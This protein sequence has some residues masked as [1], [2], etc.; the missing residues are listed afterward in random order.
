VKAT[1]LVL[2]AACATA[3]A[4]DEQCYFIGSVTWDGE[5]AD[6]AV[7][8]ISDH[9]GFVD[10][11]HLASPDSYS[12]GYYSVS[13]VVSQEPWRL[14]CWLVLDGETVPLP[15]FAAG[16]TWPDSFDYNQSWFCRIPFEW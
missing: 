15:Q 16:L 8:M 5:D 6:Y 1:I 12:F 7:V 9:A 2:I 13:R 14:D 4:T 3:L 11:L 10:S